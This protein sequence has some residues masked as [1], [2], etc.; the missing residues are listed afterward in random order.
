MTIPITP[1]DFS[2]HY[3][4]SLSAMDL[5]RLDVFLDIAEHTRIKS[6]SAQEAAFEIEVTAGQARGRVRAIYRDL[7]IAVLDK[8]TGTEKGFGQS[9]RLVLG[10]RVENPEFQRSGRIGLDE[11]GGGKLH[12]KTGGRVSAICVVRPADRCPG[13]H[14]PL[15]CDVNI[16]NAPP[17]LAA[18]VG[19]MEKQ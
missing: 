17:M 15:T 12:E 19:M 5:T 13:C 16:S 2:F 8:Q 10:E 1:S 14:Q 6:G 18:T 3:S 4:G 7:E 9:R 11:G